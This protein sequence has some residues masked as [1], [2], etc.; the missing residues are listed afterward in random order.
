MTAAG[1]LKLFPIFRFTG[2]SIHILCR[3][4]KTAVVFFQPYEM[5]L[6]GPSELLFIFHIQHMI[7]KATKLLGLSREP[8]SWF[9]SQLNFGVRHDLDLYRSA[10]VQ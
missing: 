6:K 7:Q 8:T 5:G 10:E 3:A 1:H 2:G 9:F 4:E